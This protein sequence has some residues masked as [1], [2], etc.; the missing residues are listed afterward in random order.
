MNRKQDPNQAEMALLSGTMF[1]LLP[2]QILLAAVGA[3]NGIVSSFFASNY[4]GIDAMSAVGLYGPV[5]MLIAAVSMVMVGGTS[6]VAGKYIGKNQEDMLQNVFVLDIAVTALAA[7]L[8]TALLL[9]L[10]LGDLTGV[11]TGDAAVRKLFN[12][13]LLGQA[14][15]VFPL[16]LGSQLPAFLL[17]ENRKYRTLAASLAYIAVNLALNLIFVKRFHMEALGLA[18]ASSLGMWA[19][20]FAEAHFFLTGKSHLRLFTKKIMWNDAPEII[21]IG[22]PGALS[23]GY[24]TIR[25][26]I[27]NGLLIT[28]IGSAGISAFAAANNF[29]AL[30]W[31]I[32]IGM[33]AVSRL[34]ISIS[35][36]EE[37]RESLAGVMK[38]MFRR[39]LPLMSAV[40]A[41][42]IL[43]AVPLAGIFFND[44]SEPV[45]MMTVWGFRILP[46]CMPLSVIV[47]HFISYGQ[48]SGKRLLV[49]LESLLDGVV[50]VAGFSALLVP[51]CG[52][53]GVYIANVLNGVVCVLVLV[54]YAWI[55]GGRM[56]SDVEGLMVIPDDFGVPESER[57]DLSVQNMEDVLRV[58][59][60]VYSFCLSKGSDSRRA[61]LSGL[62]MEEMAGNIVAH[63]FTKDNKKHTVGIRV[64][65]KNEDILLR[66]KDDC[67]PFNPR[68][69]ARITDPADI[70]KNIGVRMIMRIA[71]D[72]SYPNVFGLNVLTIR[73]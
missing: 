71:R 28:F 48:A 54:G 33:Q 18:L 30:F 8:F 31:A 19:F 56:P 22:I 17:L 51:L 20:F 60:Q 4:V 35:I 45:F 1:R 29:L 66:I 3:V 61:F 34:L 64:T 55:K 63:G 2:F 23:N 65:F 53:N 9:V 39:F 59:R 52:M 7:L 12:R 26:F 21:R 57:M 72:V 47:M 6:I 41:L 68:E 5:N 42:L 70:L 50:C 16:M 27:V 13:Y 10:S 49:H 15:G 58:S 62:S 38:V 40:S 73:I 24:Q 14:A 36:G 32:P 25:G 37:D 67:L 11:F 46:L 43:Y 44:P 69:R